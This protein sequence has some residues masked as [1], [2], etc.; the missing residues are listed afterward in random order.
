M[1]MAQHPTSGPFTAGHEVD[2]HIM[3]F[4]ADGH[5]IASGHLDVNAYFYR[6][7]VDDGPLFFEGRY[8]TTEKLPLKTRVHLTFDPVPEHPWFDVGAR[9]YWKWW[10]EAT[11]VVP[12]E[13]TVAVKTGP[14]VKKGP[15]TGTPSEP[16]FLGGGGFTWTDVGASNI[17]R[18]GEVS[19][20]SISLFETLSPMQ[21]GF[22]SISWRPELK[23][24]GKSSF[25]HNRGLDADE[26]QCDEASR[27]QTIVGTAW[28]AQNASGEWD[29]TQR[30]DVSRARGGTANG[31]V[32]FHPPRY[33]MEDYFA[34]N[35]AVDVTV[36]GQ[37]GFVCCA[38]GTGFAMGLPNTSGGLKD[39][40][41]VLRVDPADVSQ[42]E[43]S[44]YV[45]G[46]LTQVLTVDAAVPTFEV[47]LNMGNNKIVNMASATVSGDAVPLGQVVADFMPFIG[48][49]F[50]G[51]VTMSS[52]D[53]TFE[54]D[55]I[56]VFGTGGDAYI[57]YDGTN[58][59][60]RP[61][62]IGS[63]E[64]N[65]DG[66][67]NISVDFTAM[68]WGAGADAEIY[69]DGTDMILDPDRTSTGKLKVLGV[70]NSV[71]GFSDNGTAG[72]DA[73]IE[74]TDHD[75]SVHTVTVSGGLIT[76]WD[77]A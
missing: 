74:F 76:Q 33:L 46:T 77:T 72:I 23:V 30:P 42:I 16:G 43:L 41:A 47:A 66:I 27:P 67:V 71:G 58:L 55:I 68:R 8:P 65:I 19:S 50:V 36:A 63:G 21:E 28:G 35:S 13:T 45:S 69:F 5:T 39:N 56:A 61:K 29:Y 24:K 31:G 75:S 26:A 34:I 60:I 9:G 1:F 4:D 2:K 38:P 17:G 37:V 73:S 25:I 7:L 10:S 48:G 40:S 22:V 20:S 12:G 15:I 64:V 70:V 51:A 62:V 57:S 32:L 54:D 3:G 53:L 11:K 59:L 52:G 14:I 49:T 6:N 18:V 44:Q